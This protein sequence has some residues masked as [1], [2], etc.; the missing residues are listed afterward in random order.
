MNWDKEIFIN[1]TRIALD[2]PTYFIAD[3]AA[4]HDGDLERAKKLI[5]LAKEAGADAVKFQH[6]LAEKI[7][8]DFGFKNLTTHQSHQ[9]DWKKS[10]FD[11]YKD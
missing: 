1:K 9:S 3:I 5:Y 8:S 6:F 11:I 10:V 4:N 2:A 7:V